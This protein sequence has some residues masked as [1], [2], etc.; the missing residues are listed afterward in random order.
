MVT[1]KLKVLLETKEPM[2][3]EFRLKGS[4]V[5]SDGAETPA[6]V[7]ASAYT[8]HHA[9]G[10]LKAILGTLVDVSNF[11][12]AESIQRSRAKEALEAKRQQEKYVFHRGISSGSIGEDLDACSRI[13]EVFLTFHRIWAN[14]LLAVSLI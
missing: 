10:S 14:F 1:E 3:V 7:M 13:M 9:D 5:K 12:W 6:W 4:F 2:T 11:K 8:E